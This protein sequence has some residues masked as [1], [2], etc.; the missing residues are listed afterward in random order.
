MYPVLVRY[1]LKQMDN[2]PDHVG[3]RV[4][5]RDKMRIYEDLGTQ[6]GRGRIFEKNRCLLADWPN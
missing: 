2:Y 5:E 3:M 1:S 4:A 6:T